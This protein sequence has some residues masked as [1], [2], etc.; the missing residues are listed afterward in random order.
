MKLL[1]IRPIFY[2]VIEIINN[3]D[4]IRLPWKLYSLVWTD[5]EIQSELFFLQN[6]NISKQKKNT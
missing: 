5:F 3:Q 4:L 6:L 1:A 2:L